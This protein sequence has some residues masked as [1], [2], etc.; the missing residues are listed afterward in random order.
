MKH[1]NVNRARG[2]QHFH[3][4]IGEGG[5]ERKKEREREREREREMGMTTAINSSV[6]SSLTDLYFV[7]VFPSTG[8]QL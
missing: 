1:G 4:E 7:V 6:T 8:H 5:R 2:Y 3:S